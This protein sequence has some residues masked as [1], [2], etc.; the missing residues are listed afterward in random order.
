[1]GCTSVNL[2]PVFYPIFKVTKGDP[3]IMAIN[4]TLENLSTLSTESL[5]VKRFDPNIWV[6]Q[7]GPT[8]KGM[9]SFSEHRAV[10]ETTDRQLVKQA[11]IRDIQMQDDY[12]PGL[13]WP[14]R[15]WGLIFKTN[16]RIENTVSGDVLI[17]PYEF[18]MYLNS[19]AGLALP[20]KCL[21]FN[22]SAMAEFYNSI[23]AGVPESLTL[24][25]FS[26]GQTD[27]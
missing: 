15:T 1:M 21:E 11:F 27:F 23:A 17:P 16:W 9:K 2:E 18:R 8:P 6:K 7:S 19:A 14:G 12:V 4:T 24:G 10:G 3:N 22:H 25:K 5:L 26:I 13:V 20:V